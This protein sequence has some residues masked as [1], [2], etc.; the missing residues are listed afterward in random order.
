MCAPLRIPRQR[1]EFLG[2][3]QASTSTE[4]ARPT[5]KICLPPSKSLSGSGLERPSKPV[6]RSKALPLH[7]W[8]PTVAPPKKADNAEASGLQ[9]FFPSYTAQPPGAPKTRKSRAHCIKAVVT[10]LDV[11]GHFTD[12]PC[13]P[14]EAN[15]LKGAEDSNGSGRTRAHSLNIGRRTWRAL[16][17]S[18]R[19]A[20]GLQCDPM[21]DDVHTPPRWP[22]NACVIG[23]PGISNGFCS[24]LLSTT[25]FLL[26]CCADE[27]STYEAERRLA[28]R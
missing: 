14:A 11:A 21:E 7:N 10:N 3:T 12:P 28:E 6:I 2:I 15:D 20:P 23:D 25:S 18:G 5:M 1:K 9:S 24:L 8:F 4:K 27:N 26:L 19:W 17:A 13:F 16:P 22:L